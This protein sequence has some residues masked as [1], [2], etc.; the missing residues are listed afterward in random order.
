MDRAVEAFLRSLQP[1][2]LDAVEVSGTGRSGLGWK[3]YTALAYPEF[4]LLSPGEP[5]TFDVVICEQVLEHVEDPFLAARTLAAMCRPGGHVVVSV[6]FMLRIHDHPGDFWRF[7]EPGLIRVLTNAGLDVVGSGSWGNRW[8]V[9]ANFDRWVGPERARR[10][11]GSR[12][13]RNEPTLPMVVWAF[14]RR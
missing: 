7:T 8:C 4:D 11:L 10:L 14:G 13:F 12:A 9:M 3:S 1:S 2:R 5:G 6:P